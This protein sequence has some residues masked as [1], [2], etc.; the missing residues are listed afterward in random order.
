MTYAD[1]P[2]DLLEISVDVYGGVREVT[3]NYNRDLFRKTVRPYG[4]R[5]DLSSDKVEHML[6]VF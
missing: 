2:H 5:Q 3:G 1:G 6:G 4:G